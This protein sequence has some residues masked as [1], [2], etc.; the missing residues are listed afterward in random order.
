MSHKY[1]PSNLIERQKLINLSQYYINGGYK[2]KKY[3]GREK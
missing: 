3:N 1:T 2:E